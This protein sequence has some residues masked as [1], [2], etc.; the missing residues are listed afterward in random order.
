MSTKTLHSK[1]VVFCG[2][3]FPYGKFGYG[4]IHES[5]TIYKESFWKDTREVIYT[6]PKTFNATIFGNARNRTLQGNSISLMRCGIEE[7]RKG[8]T[9]SY[10]GTFFWVIWVVVTVG[11]VVSFYI[12]ENDWLED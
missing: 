6:T 11:V 9:T 12:F 8:L 3:T 5:E 2:V 4:N 7:Y 10:L 1:E